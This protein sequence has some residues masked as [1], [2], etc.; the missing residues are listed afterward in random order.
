MKFYHMA[1]VHLG[2]VPE[3]GRSFGRLREQEIWDTFRDILERARSEKPDCLFLCGDLFHRQPL[4][5]EL[6]EVSYL[7]SQ[8]PD[9]RVFLMAG[10]H[11][12]LKPGSAYEK[13]AWGDNVT[14]LD[15]EAVEPVY[16]PEL[17]LTVYGHSYRQREITEPIY[18]ALEPNG[19]PGMHVLMAHGGD[20]KHIPINYRRL[21]ARGFDYVAMGHIH[22]PGMYEGYP[23]AYAGA[24]EPLDVND[25]GPHGY[26]EGTI[27]PEKGTGHFRCET[28]FVPAARRSYIH[29]PIALKEDMTAF[30]LEQSIR[31]AIEEQGNGN[32]FKLILKGVRNPQAELSWERLWELGNIVEIMDVS[33]AAY[34]YVQLRQQYRG[35]LIGQFLESYGDGELSKLEEQSR[36]Y[37]LEALLES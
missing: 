10:N 2:A 15:T 36:L 24:P 4:K 18:D 12:Y 35:Q 9:T 17:H 3:K 27:F 28:V 37:G 23:M 8:I 29:L 6:K 22:R 31:E 21:G 33:R 11:D 32:L 20:A 19:N 34:D 16:V 5:R 14:F 25:I 7:F 26:V 13:F 1:D 30:A